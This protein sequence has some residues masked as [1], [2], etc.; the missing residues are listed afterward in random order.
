MIK[1]PKKNSHKIFRLRNFKKTRKLIIS[2]RVENS[3]SGPKS[4]SP[5]RSKVLL[6]C[7]LI[8][9]DQQILLETCRKMSHLSRKKPEKPFLKNCVSGKFC[10]VGVSKVQYH[11]KKNSFIRIHEIFF[12]INFKRTCQ[13]RG[14]MVLRPR[15]MK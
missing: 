3:I 6:G 11:S 12:S 10:S 5:N 1:K 7:L 9:K 13:P 14:K 4:K 2:V 15:W 8:H